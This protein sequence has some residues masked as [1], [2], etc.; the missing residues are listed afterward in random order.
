MKITLERSDDCEA[1]AY[2]WWMILD[3]GHMWGGTIND[4][5]AMVTGPFFSRASAEAHLKARRHAYSKKA[6][7]YCHTGHHSVEYVEATKKSLAASS[8]A[9]REQVP[10]V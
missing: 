9:P 10:S 3:P 8:A 1:T 5:A 2:P 4:V 6:A 7:V